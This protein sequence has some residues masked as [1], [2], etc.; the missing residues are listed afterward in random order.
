MDSDQIGLFF[1]G[2]IA[3]MAPDKITVTRAVLGKPAEKK[4]FLI[5]PTT[6]VEGKMRAKV[7]V[8]VR[9]KTT[10]DGDVAKSILVRNPQA[11]KP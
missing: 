3:D 7:R 6:K 2:T 1:S 8:T 11:K 9:Y 5:D 4:V 10:E